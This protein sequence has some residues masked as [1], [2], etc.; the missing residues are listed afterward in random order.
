MPTF[1]DFIPTFPT[2]NRKF[3]ITDFRL[4]STS[5]KRENFI[6]FYRSQKKVKD[7]RS[8]VILFIVILKVMILSMVIL[9]VVINCIIL[10]NV[11]LQS[12]ATFIMLSVI[13]MNVVLLSIIMLS[14]IMLSVIAPN[15]VA[16]TRTG[17]HR[18]TAVLFRP[19]L[20]RRKVCSKVQIL[21]LTSLMAGASFF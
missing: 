12:F 16:P 4:L 1:T 7:P 3:L 14:V 19:V 15:A 18:C 8:L 20:T 10:L 6:D 13:M 21:R 5:V 17:M 9:S 2:V 11:I